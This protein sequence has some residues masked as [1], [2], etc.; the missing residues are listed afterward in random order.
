V[1]RT[2]C[3]SLSC[4]LAATFSC[5]GRPA[6][7]PPRPTETPQPAASAD[8]AKL[9]D[10]FW[11]HTLETDV[12]ARMTAR[13]PVEHFQDISAAATTAEG[14]FARILIADLGRLD[15]RALSH[16]DDLT[17]RTLL[18]RARAMAELDAFPWYGWIITPYSSPASDAVDIFA[19]QPL[20]T[21][22]D[23]DHYV[24]LLGVLAA[25]VATYRPFLEGQASRGVVLPKP[26]LPKAHRLFAGLAMPGDKSPFA[27]SAARLS[28]LAVPVAEPEATAFRARVD[29]TVA[30]TLIP[31]FQSLLDYLDGEYARRAPEALGLAHYPEGA[32][33]YRALVRA[34]T[35]LDVTPEEV[36]RIGLESVATI[37]AQED[38]VIRANGLS[39]TRDDVRHFLATDP[40]FFAHSP[41]EVKSRALAFMAKVEPRVKDFFL[42]V[43]RAPYGVKRLD[44]SLEGGQTWGHYTQPVGD[45]KTGYYLF[46][47]GDLAHRPVSSLAPMILHELVPGHHFQINLQQEN[48]ALPAFRRNT[49]LG[50]PS[51][52]WGCYAS[53]LG[54]L[55]GAYDPSDRFAELDLDMFTAVRLV[56]DTGLN[57]FGWSR[58]RA[59]EY[60]K[61]H[62]TT[63]LPQLESEVLRYGAD[64]P[65]QAL[66]YK[67]GEREL[68]RLREKARS[69][70]GPRF[71]IRAYHDWVLSEGALPLGVLGE[72]VDWEI[73]RTLA[74][75]R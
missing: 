42:H 60:M 59:L 36:H 35:T 16:E 47:G 7:A 58:E 14:D 44:P 12:Y 20:A 73:A 2:A 43:P 49:F 29:R 54:V 32:A 40:R 23:R 24:H 4:F 61:A 22:A 45:E 67:M 65:A 66:G 55:M 6:P 72:H 41:D 37:E 28:A 52:G 26:E 48:T 63:P 21:P 50:A 57:A 34:R 8:L 62:L 74:S 46:N 39:G 13:L 9:A 56:V 19:A 68:I 38:E 27:I 5:G 70:L 11:Q 31:A 71:D 30:E 15:E 51:E 18:W 75:S 69:A 17:Y 3:C 53:D 64:M 33:Y 10:R 1:N 25:H